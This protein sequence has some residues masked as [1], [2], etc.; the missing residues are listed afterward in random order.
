[1][2]SIDVKH[3]K[4]VWK[5]KGSKLKNPNVYFAVYM[6]KVYYVYRDDSFVIFMIPSNCDITY[7]LPKKY[8]KLRKDKEGEKY[9]KITSI[10][11]ASVVSCIGRKNEFEKLIID[12]IVVNPGC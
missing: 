12:D 10:E 1:M 2:E 8:C 4:S 3:V 7:A 9:Y 5:K 11:N 6:D